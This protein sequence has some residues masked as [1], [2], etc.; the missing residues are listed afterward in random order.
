MARR[1]Q[2][3][4]NSDTALRLP[5]RRLDVTP[6]RRDEVA[7]GTTTGRH[8][9]EEKASP[10]SRQR[11]LRAVEQK[12]AV[13]APAR[14]LDPKSPIG[15]DPGRRRGTQICACDRFRAASP[16]RRPKYRPAQS[17]ASKRNRPVPEC[18]SDRHERRR[19]TAGRPDLRVKNGKTYNSNISQEPHAGVKGCVLALFCV[20]DWTREG[21]PAG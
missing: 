17:D 18:R 19:A 15:N 7:A 6:S 8:R 12:T 1:R 2:S 11:C 21:R 14:R 13:V 5:R 10:A 3:G 9:F 20:R 16:C 4:R